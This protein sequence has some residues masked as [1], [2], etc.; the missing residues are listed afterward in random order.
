MANTKQDGAGEKPTE[1][2]DARIIIDVTE[3]SF[4][5]SHTANLDLEQIYL[6]FAAALN[7][8]ESLGE[9]PPKFLN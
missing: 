4:K 1:D 2:F 3:D 6:I 9:E 7:Y 5:V 8:M